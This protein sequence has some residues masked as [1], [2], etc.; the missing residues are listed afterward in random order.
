MPPNTKII[1]DAYLA[2][3]LF[4]DGTLCM[5]P[6]KVTCQVGID[7]HVRNSAVLFEVEKIFRKAG[8]KYYRYKIPDKKERVRTYSKELYKAF[9]SLRSNPAAYFKSLRDMEKRKFVAGFFDAEGTAT[10][11]LVIY[12]GNKKILLAVKEWLKT[13]GVQGN[14]YRFGKIFGLQIY[15][16]KSVRSFLR[17]IKPVRVSSLWLRNLTE[18]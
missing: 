3:V 9:N 5:W 15:R 2:G 10:D 17:Y 4:G 6:N 7:Q 1:M 8:I 16:K 14:I 18:R 11:R 12:N 13:I